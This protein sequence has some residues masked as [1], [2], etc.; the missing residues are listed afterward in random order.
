MIIPQL[1]IYAVVNTIGA[2]SDDSFNGHIH[3]VDNSR[4]MLSSGQGTDAPCTVTRFNQVLN[5]QVNPVNVQMDISI[6]DIRWFRDG[7]IITDPAQQ[8][9]DKS[10]LYGS[11]TTTYWAAI[12]NDVQGD[13]QYQ[14]K[15]NMGGKDVW[16]TS[17]PRIYVATAQEFH[18][19][20]RFK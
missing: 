17:F 13:Y 8:P 6:S 15:L 2:L 11:P 1:N 14:L 7:E 3:I 16:M 12:V 9:V 18:R 20:K 4:S 19:A 10:K 5:W